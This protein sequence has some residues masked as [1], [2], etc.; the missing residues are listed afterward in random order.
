MG[1][2]SRWLRKL[3]LLANRRKYADELGEE[4]TFHREQV[5]KEFE[6]DG[7]SS[8]AAHYAAARQFG[9]STRLLEQ[10]QEIIRFRAET[11]VQDLRYAVRQLRK[12]P[13][14]A[15]TAIVILA[16]GIGATTAIFS[17]VNP[18][19]FEP[20]PYPQAGRLTMVWYRASDG[21][22]SDQTFG[23]YREV[24]QRSRSFDEVAVIKPWQP[25]MTSAD[26]PERLEGQRVSVGYFRVLGLGPA[27]GR[28]FQAS[29]DQLNGPNVVILSDALWRR[30][31]GGDNEIVGRQIPLDDQLFTVVGVMPRKLENVLAPA[32]EIWAPLQ[33]DMSLGTAWGHHLRMVARLRPNVSIAQARSELDAIARMP[34]AEFP[35]ARWAALQ[36]GLIVN[37]LQGDVTGGVKPSLLAIIGAVML[38]LLIACVNV[39]NLLLAR[40]VQRRGE[41]AMRAALGARRARL[42]RQLLTES[43]LLAIIGGALGMLVAQYGVRALI[44]LSPPGLPRANAIVLDGPVLGFAIGVTTLVGLV[45]GLLPAFNASRRDPR[46]GLQLSSRAGGANQ[47]LT[48]RT[49]VVAE[50]SLAFVL[51]VSAGLLLRSLQRLFA[52]DPGF[53]SSHL[54]TMQ[55]QA[56][57]HRFDKDATDRFFTQ[58]LEAVRQVPGVSAAAFTSQLPLSGDDDEYGVR[59][60]GDDPN[61]GYSVFRYAVSPSY[62]QTAGIPLRRGRAIDERDAAGAPL[63][64]VV[65]ESLAKSKFAGRDPIGQRL[66]IGPANAPW[67]I[68]V[69]VAGNV[70]QAS[71]ALSQTWA[72][73]IATKQSWFVDNELSFVAR[74]HGDAAALAPA[75]REAIWSVDKDQPIVRVATMDNLLAATEA[76]RHFASIL[77]ETF[78]VMALLL[79]AVGL[80]GVLSG[81]VNER[82]RELGVRSA[83]GAPRN[84]ILGLVIRQGM[85]LTAIGIAIGIGGAVAASQALVTLL[86]GISPVDPTT[87][88]G[89]VALLLGVSMVACWVPAWHASRVDP[90]IILRAE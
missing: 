76:Q 40:S 78:A 1:A 30:R 9:N 21:S 39:T 59:F 80:Y 47:Q 87:Y 15:T 49:L 82:M 37:S 8:E 33:Y 27:L 66:H 64:V 4:M 26:Q 54:L 67:F 43:L 48:R 69:G 38:L 88:L 46:S 13:G 5:E 41:F 24:A 17:A 35:R 81:N 19:L 50:V 12:N 58:A 90:A 20:L 68:I 32:A 51:L 18:I 11:A 2:A 42:L 53:D 71:L 57:G 61:M 70:R 44:A 74:V 10:S 86:F 23:T 25:A 60:D 77:F 6:A 65:S 16:L 89:V 31:F 83:L 36:N 56:S 73:Y 29:D 72:V 14:F 3:W 62:F 45:V 75:I 22:R 85:L 28:D 7:M 63:A 52:I 84:N 34:V 79:A 55:V